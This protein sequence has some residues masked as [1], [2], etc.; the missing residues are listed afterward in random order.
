MSRQF[1]LFCVRHGKIKTFNGDALP[2]A[3]NGVFD[4]DLGVFD[5]ATLEQCSDA[6]LAAIEAAV[7]TT[8][9]VQNETREQQ[10]DRM[11]ASADAARG[12]NVYRPEDK[13]TLDIQVRYRDD[14]KGSNV[15]EI[16][17]D[18]PRSKPTAGPMDRSAKV[19]NP[20]SDSLFTNASGVE[21]SKAE[22]YAL[23]GGSELKR[24]L[25]RKMMNT[26]LSRL[27]RI[28]AGN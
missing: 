24:K 22:V 25:F 26:D 14:G 20:H 13:T 6:C 9:R 12:Y 10:R 27:N 7:I 11:R 23:A 4:L 19:V 5:G 21:Y 3:S 15:F 1:Q 18:S 2:L 16:V 8:R 28:L 17:G